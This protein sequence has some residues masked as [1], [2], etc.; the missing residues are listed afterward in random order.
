M[1][2]MML[3]VEGHPKGARLGLGLASQAT[4]NM[5]NALGALHRQHADLGHTADTGRLRMLVHGDLLR[6]HSVQAP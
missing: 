6:R 4:D 2:H 5:K 1:G 3:K